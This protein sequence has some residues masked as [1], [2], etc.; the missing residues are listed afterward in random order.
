[1]IAATNPG[2]MDISWEELDAEGTTVAQTCYND[3]SLTAGC[4]Y[5]ISLNSNGGC[6]IADTI[7]VTNP[8]GSTVNADYTTD[9]S[10]AGS[11]SVE[12]T[13]QG[14]GGA[15][16]VFGATRGDQVVVHAVPYLGESF[17]GWYENGIMVSSDE[18]YSFRIEQ[19][20]FLT[21]VFSGASSPTV[22]VT[23]VTASAAKTTLSIG[24][25][26]TITAE[27]LPSNATDK[28]LTYTSSDP[29]TLTVSPSGEVTAKKAGAATVTVT[30]VDNSEAKQEIAFEVVDSSSTKADVF[31]ASITGL[32]TK[33][34][35]GKKQI[36]SP[37]VQLNGRT[38]KAGTDYD[39]S[40]LNNVNAGAATI[41][42]TGKGGYTGKKSAAFKINKA[43]QP[44]AATGKSKTVK[45][46]SLKKKSVAAKK[47]IVVK[48]AKGKVTYKNVSKSKMLKKFKVNSK[49]GAITIPKGTKTGTYKLQVKATAKGNANYKSG[50]KIIEVKIRVK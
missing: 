7:A 38:L 20:R 45:A 46:K 49:N 11:L 31:N 2:A 35:T 5:S 25:S 14:N 9:S 41:V 21:A 28:S 30:S 33:T 44:M 47:L 32:K 48:K 3:L 22:S 18:N 17:K 16:G 37:V 10:E 26:T 6:S 36:Q 42:I 29:A 12:V 8:D 39:V 43:T 34:Y 15:R 4:S 27:A 1:V 13:A 24:E 19:S 23:S 50:S 40:Y